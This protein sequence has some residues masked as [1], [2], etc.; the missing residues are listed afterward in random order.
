MT[1]NYKTLDENI[2]LLASKGYTEKGLNL[3]YP[4]DTI[5]NL[6]GEA[7][8]HYASLAALTGKEENF[9]LALPARFDNAQDTVRFRINF[10]L[11]PSQDR[12]RITALSASMDNFKQL[13]ILAARAEIQ[14]AEVIYQQLSDQ[15]THKVVQ[16]L[17]T[18]KVNPIKRTVHL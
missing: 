7:Y 8:Q 14:P 9:V 18:R 10:R 1:T 5:R 11:D 4:P 12:L 17:E 15:R 13:Q 6:L 16:L 3:D 2:A